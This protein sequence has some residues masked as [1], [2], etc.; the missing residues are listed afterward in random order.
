MMAWTR[1][2][3]PAEP[4]APIAFIGEARYRVRCPGVARLRRLQHLRNLLTAAGQTPPAPPGPK[5]RRS[6]RGG[7]ARG[8]ASQE[9]RGLGDTSRLPVLPAVRLQRTRQICVI[10]V[11]TVDHRRIHIYGR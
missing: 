8:T 7:E 2:R 5:V 10:I 3:S 9:R 6:G 4:G 1:L 11:C